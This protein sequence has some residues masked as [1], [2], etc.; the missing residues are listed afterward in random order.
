MEKY[1]YLIIIIIILLL[2]GCSEKSESP[3]EVD[4]PEKLYPYDT[5]FDLTTFKERRNNLV[6]NISDN[7]IAIVTTN[8]LYLRNGDVNFEFRPAS[9]F[10]YLTGFDEPNAIAVIREKSEG[11]ESSEMIMFVEEREG[12]VEQWLGP[13]Y[14]T[15][16]AVELFGADSAYTFEE[17]GSKIESYFNSEQYE[18]FYGNL[19][20]NASVADTFYNSVED[21]FNYYDITEIVYHMRM[22][23]SPIEINAIQKAVDVAV[24]AFTEAMKVITPDMYEYEVD[25]MF[26][27]IL[28]LNGCPRNAF[29]TIV[30]SGP[31]INTLHYEAN[32]R[33]MLDGDLVMIDFGAEYGYYASDI[34]RTL[35]VNGNFSNEQESIY[36]IVL[37]AHEAVLAAAAP[38]ESYY[39]LYYLSRD[40]IL[41]R[42]LEKGIISGKKS[43]IISSY[44]YRQY[45]PAGLGHCVGLDVHD[46][47][48][49]NLQGDKIL[50]ENMV[51]AIEP[52]IYL[53]ENDNTVQQEYWNVSAR[54]ED[55][56]LITS[57]GCEVLSSA[58]PR[59][60]ESIEELMND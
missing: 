42:L 46:P 30:A 51:L 60:I 6:D 3:T 26:D 36:E 1:R 9:N 43:E 27:Y 52:H 54:I 5:S 39:Y 31:N 23:K 33:K 49:R 48:L 19:E 21:E 20:I 45:I 47:F 24:Q 28:R 17:F 40:I 16:G 11:S 13:V 10:Y 55:V 41:D 50:Q 58:L 14:G 12:V 32:Q 56:I 57:D 29:P 18:N 35:P 7:S 37:E 22:I 34:T 38:G 53:Y 4:F 59:T 25:A 15:E 44:A 8:D 2:F